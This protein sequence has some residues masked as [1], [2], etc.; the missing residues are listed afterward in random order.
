MSIVLVEIGIF[1]GII[2]GIVQ[3]CLMVFR[4]KP[5]TPKEPEKDKEKES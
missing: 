4:K 1:A 2:I 3:V 5:A